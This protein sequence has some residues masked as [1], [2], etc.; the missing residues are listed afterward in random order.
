VRAA[1]LAALLLLSPAAA[2]QEAVEVGCLSLSLNP[3]DKAAATVGRLAWRGGC[4][5]SAEA[6]GFGGFSGLVLAPD[7]SGLTAIS[8]EGRWLTAAIA[9]DA[10]GTLAGLADARLGPLHDRAGRLLSVS[11]KRRQDAEALARLPDGSLV[12]AFEREHRLRRFTAGLDGPTELFDAPPAL[13][14]AADNA[15]IEAMV[16]LA[17]G[18]LLAFGEEQREDGRTTAWL[19][20]ASGAWQTLTLRPGGLFRPTDAALLPDGDVLLLERRYTLLGGFGARVSRIA[21][22]DVRPGVR[23]EAETLAEFAP[24]LTLDNFEG[25]AA[26]RA[27]DGTT[28]ITLLSDDNFNAFQRTLIVQFEV[29]E[30]E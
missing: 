8:D 28:R 10:D 18:R 26:H 4:A 1:L 25:I 21:A 22:D 14:E 16:T 3:E 23:L 5:L 17:D 29:V 19:R 7:G 9:Y 15:G 20:E 13:A 11:I 12:V 24:P 27:A 6:D 30:A 2:A